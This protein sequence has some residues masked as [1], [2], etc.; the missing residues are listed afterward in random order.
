MSGSLALGF[1][2]LLHA[3]V[4]AGEPQ[5]L[6]TPRVAREVLREV[7]RFTAPEASQG[8]AVDARHFYAIGDREIGKYDKL[9]GERVAAWRDADG[10][11]I[12]H[13]NGGVAI[14]GRL[15][16]AHSNYPG[17]PMASSIEVFDTGSLRHLGSHSFGV[18]QGSATWVDRRDGRWWVAFAHY[19]EKGG[20]PGK[21]VAWTSLVAFDDEWRRVAGWVFPADVVERLRPYSNSGGAWGSDGLLYATGHDAAE[22]YVLRLPDAGSV[23][24]SLRVIP[25]PLAGQGIAW[26]R[27]EAGI[28]YGIVK[29]RREVVAMR[30]AAGDETPARGA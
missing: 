23:L 1:A 11:A 2:A 6:F 8:V 10:G 27:D 26:D 14:D 16:C 28:L 5:A 3:H 4:S 21:G 18:F 24:E 13:L 29:A 30:V 15:H 22:V 25:A 7:R 12:L 9:S 19:D 20:E 17:V